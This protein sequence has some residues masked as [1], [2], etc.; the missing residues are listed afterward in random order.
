MSEGPA[1]ILA[2]ASPRR[3]ALLRQLHVPFTVVAADIDEGQRPG[4]APL[5]YALRVA[6]DKARHVVQRFPHALVLAADT[7]VVLDDEV[8]GK[9]PDAEAARRMLQR[10][11]GRQHTVITA[12]ALHREAPPLALQAAVETRVR[13]RTLSAEEIEAYVASGEPLDKAGAYAIQGGA[14]AFVVALEGCYSNVVGLPLRRTAALLR[15]AG[16]AVRLS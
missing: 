13:F 1:L 16:M 3:Q 8:L 14:A 15:Q 9:P 12:L 4:E 10:L 7:I 5:A 6:Q 11:S 2:S